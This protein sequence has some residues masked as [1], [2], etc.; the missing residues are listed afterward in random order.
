MPAAHGEGRLLGQVL[1]SANNN[2]FIRNLTRFAGY[3]FGDD[4]TQLV[5]IENT[6]LVSSLDTNSLLSSDDT[7]EF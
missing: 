1:S 6:N 4:P 2:N 7:E 3:D 5:K